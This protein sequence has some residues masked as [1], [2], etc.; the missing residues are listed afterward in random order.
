MDLGSYFS[1]EGFTSSH[2]SY[3]SMTSKD[4]LFL[5]I[6]KLKNNQEFGCYVVNNTIC[7]ALQNIW[8]LKSF[9]PAKGKSKVVVLASEEEIYWGRGIFAEFLKSHNAGP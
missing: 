2:Q 5:A 4:L 8:T 1:A 6:A 9:K 7:F 3:V